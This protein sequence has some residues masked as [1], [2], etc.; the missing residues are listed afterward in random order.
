MEIKN[1]IGIR[2]KEARA[3]LGY[4]QDKLANESGISRTNK[5]QLE[6]AK[7]NKPSV[8]VMLRLA[9]ALDQD[10]YFFLT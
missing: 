8:W 3:R 7:S 1:I 5:I 9:E 10:I 6:G 4:S 2:M